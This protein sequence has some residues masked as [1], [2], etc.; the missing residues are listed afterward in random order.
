MA[1]E[2]VNRMPKLRT[3]PKMTKAERNAVAD[4][5]ENPGKDV[6]CPNCGEPLSYFERGNSYG[7]RCDKCNYE[8]G[9]RGV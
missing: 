6:R 7:S 4:K 9:V 3:W 1:T 8:D 5:C 2:Q